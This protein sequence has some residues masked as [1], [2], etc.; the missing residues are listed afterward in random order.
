[1]QGRQ[2]E[3][4][5]LESG[6]A[7][8]QAVLRLRTSELVPVTLGSEMAYSYQIRT[9]PRIFSAYYQAIKSRAM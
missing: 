4:F 8:N 9:K 5:T 6:L 1:M 3:L 2:W 7:S